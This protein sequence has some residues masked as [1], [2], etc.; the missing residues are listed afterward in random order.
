MTSS[1]FFI[2]RLY[3]CL[4]TLFVLILF[5]E[6]PTTFIKMRCRFVHPS[7]VIQYLYWPYS[8]CKSSRK[9]QRFTSTTWRSNTDKPGQAHREGGGID[10]TTHKLVLGGWWSAPGSDCFTS[11]EEYGAHCT[12]CR[13]SLPAGLGEKEN[14][15]LTGIRSPY[16]YT[17]YANPTAGI[18]WL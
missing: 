16:R 11:R 6:P 8:L 2:L 3:L 12:G 1:W 9:R 15:S 13:V 17:D 14:I 4:F 5:S 10:P 7:T 18:L